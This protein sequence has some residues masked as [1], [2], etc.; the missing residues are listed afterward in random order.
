MARP[1]PFT[2]IERLEA[3]MEK[4]D[5]RNEDECWE[6][7]ASKNSYGY[8]QFNNGITM[9]GAHRFM[10]ESVNG[11]IPES[12]QILHKCNNRACVNPDHLYIGDSSD[13]HGDMLEA[14]TYVKAHPTFRKLY[15]EEIWLIRRL[16]AGRIKQCL[17][18]KMFKVHKATITKVRHNPN[19][20]SRGST[21]KE[22]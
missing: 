3:F 4:V 18:A 8:G 11:Q 10:W 7:L 21:N 17:I 12:K 19:F 14:G 9:I 5:K 20:P 22:T 15:D 1:I 2:D 13:N 16:L 6:W